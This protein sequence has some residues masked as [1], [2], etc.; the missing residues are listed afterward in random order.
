MLLD[1]FEIE[2]PE[3]SGN[4]LVPVMFEFANSEPRQVTKGVSRDDTRAS[5][6]KAVQMC[7]ETNHKCVPLS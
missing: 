1:I 2:D 7:I 5:Q 4:V 6:T 3:I